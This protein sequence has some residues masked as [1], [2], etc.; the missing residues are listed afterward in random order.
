MIP[1]YRVASNETTTRVL[2][3]AQVDL[4]G[5]IVRAI[6]SVSLICSLSVL[7]TVVILRQLRTVPNFVLTCSSVANIFSSIASIIGP[8]E[9]SLDPR[10]YCQ[11][12]AFLYQT[13]RQFECCWFLAMVITVWIAFGK[14]SEPKNPWRWFCVYAA[15]FIVLPMAVAA[16]L[17]AMDVYGNIGVWCWIERDHHYLSVATFTSPRV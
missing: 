12:Q 4:V 9:I 1:L 5:L 10:G 8:N 17:L 3:E 6:G 7:L 15:A 2:T 14:Q 11:A 16:V 13:F